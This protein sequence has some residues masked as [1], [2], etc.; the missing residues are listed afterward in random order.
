M[1]QRVSD[2]G[3]NSWGKFAEKAIAF[4]AVINIFFGHFSNAFYAKVDDFQTNG[5]SGNF[6]GKFLAI[7]KAI[8]LCIFHEM[9]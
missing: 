9:N 1:F 3:R 7:Q 2:Y 8:I 6:L 5:F 4:A